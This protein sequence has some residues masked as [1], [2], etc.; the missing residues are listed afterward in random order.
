VTPIQIYHD[1]RSPNCQKVR[2]VAYELDVTATF[3]PV[4]L[5]AGDQRAPSFVAVNPNGAVPVL[6]DGDFVLWESNAIV[7]YLAHGT[8]LLP[9]QRRARAE[10]ERWNAWHL[11][12]IGPAIW[13]VAFERYLKPML[14]L[15]APDDAA[16][17]HGSTDYRR[18]T[19]MLDRAL[20]DR[21]YVAGELSVA[22]FV[23]AP[24][25]VLGTRVG[26]DTVEFPN[27]HAWLDRL[28]ARPSLQRTFAD[29]AGER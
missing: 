26:L 10:V 16:I 27:V 4:D 7:G 1:P 12:H 23:L 25:Y 3:L 29:A 17:A 24:M 6:I 22:D 18:L 2:A 13:K 5:L 19:A 8:P 11:A 20:G 28:L 14:E 21:R 15:G 9:D